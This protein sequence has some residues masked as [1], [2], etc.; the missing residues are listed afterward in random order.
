MSLGI[1]IGPGIGGFLAEIHIKFPLFFSGVISIT[2]AIITYYVFG[3]VKS[4]L[5]IEIEQKR[6]KRESIM[7]QL[8]RSLKTEYFM[9]LLIVFVFSLGLSNFQ[10]TL[11]LYLD[12]KFGY[13][14]LEISSFLLLSSFAGVVL[15]LFVLDKLFKKFGE[16]KVILVCLFISVI[17]MLL[18]IYVST[19]FLILVVVVLFTIAIT[20]IRLAVNSV[21]SKFAGNEQGYAAGM[22]NA[23]M[24]L[25]TTIG[26]IMA[27]ILFDWHIDS[28]FVIGAIILFLSLVMCFIWIRSK[29]QYFSMKDMGN[30]KIISSEKAH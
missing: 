4:D 13:S 30:N 21:I 5:K 6:Q 16:M 12:E 28:P 19:Y 17:T 20:F 18:M 25:G 9:I 26:P 8:M 27:G 2:A 14:P 23:Y 1:M 7:T 15:Q 3:N 11:S 24:S 22:N 29:A 10:L